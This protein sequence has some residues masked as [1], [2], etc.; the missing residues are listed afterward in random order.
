MQLVPLASGH[1]CFNDRLFVRENPHQANAAG[2]LEV[3]RARI[4]FPGTRPSFWW[5]LKRLL[6]K[7]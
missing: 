7:M 3:V 6:T 5:H 4:A 2:V 1:R